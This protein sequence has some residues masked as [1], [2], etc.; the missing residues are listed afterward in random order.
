MSGTTINNDMGSNMFGLIRFKETM[1]KACILTR[2][3]IYY[4]KGLN[5][6]TGGLKLRQVFALNYMKFEASNWKLRVCV[7]VGGGVIILFRA[8]NCCGS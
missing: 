4:I 7:V 6:F 3:L 5:S 1:N 8:C 2:G